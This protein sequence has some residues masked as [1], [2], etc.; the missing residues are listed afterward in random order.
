MKINRPVVDRRGLPFIRKKIELMTGERLQQTGIGRRSASVGEA[1][2]LYFVAAL[3]LTTNNETEILAEIG[4][5]PQSA[6]Y[7]NKQLRKPN[8]GLKQASMAVFKE[9]N[10]FQQLNIEQ[11]AAKLIA[12][13]KSEQKYKSL[14]N[15]VFDELNIE[16]C[17][18]F[19]EI[20]EAL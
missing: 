16:S 3:H 2:L 6:T 1:R 8:F 15:C 14:L 9:L 20:R 12:V 10:V 19:D 18:R 7:Y 4:V 17:S 5:S 13:E 11:I